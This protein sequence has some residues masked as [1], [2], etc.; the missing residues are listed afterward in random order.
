VLPTGSES[1][2]KPAVPIRRCL[3]LHRRC[4]Q[5]PKFFQSCQ[6]YAARSF[7]IRLDKLWPVELG[8]ETLLPARVTRRRIRAANIATD[9]SAT[10]AEVPE[11]P[12]KISHRKAATLP[13]RH[14]LFHA[15]AIK[16][17]GDVDIFA[18]DASQKMFKTSAPIVAQDCAFAFSILLISIVC[19]RM[20][21]ENSSA[22]RAT[23]AE[24]L[25]WPPA[26]KIAATPNTRTQHIWKFQ[27]TIDP[28]T[29]GPFRWAYIPIRMVIERNED[30]RF[31]EGAQPE[32]GQIMKIARS[33]EQKRRGQICL[34]VAIESFD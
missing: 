1:L 22:F 17:Y 34:V 2:A 14:R 15:Q 16:I 20:H 12:F 28:P 6:I 8:G 11:R 29:A 30:G 32:G 18:S 9:D 4:E 5:R 23:V 24:N 33:I 25:M 10:R 21:S 31:G 3:A 13:V 19:P 7:N 26:F 27:G